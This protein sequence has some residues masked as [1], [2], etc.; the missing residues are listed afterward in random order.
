MKVPRKFLGQYVEVEWVD[1]FQDTYDVIRGDFPKGRD[2]L[3]KWKER[4]VLVDITEGVLI[5]QHSVCKLAEQESWHV[6]HTVEDLVTSIRA[7]QEVPE[8][9]L[10]G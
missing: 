2:S 6:T 7:L 5:I 10:S 1:P 9:S 4:G 8:E 3:G